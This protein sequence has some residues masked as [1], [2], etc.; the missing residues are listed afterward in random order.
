[1][2]L[3]SAALS[4]ELAGVEYRTDPIF[5]FE[6]P[7]AVPGVSGAL[8]DPRTTW[9]DPEAY[10]EKARE[11]GKMFNENFAKFGADDNLVQAGP[12]V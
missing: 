4:G 9:S 10:D 5:G 6:V 12:R 8:L 11:L 3:L 7:V 1:R 2:A